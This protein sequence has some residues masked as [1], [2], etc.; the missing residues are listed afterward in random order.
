LDKT[1]LWCYFIFR[2]QV[3]NSTPNQLQNMIYAFSFLFLAL[4]V[5]AVIATSINPNEY[6]ALLTADDWK[7]GR[8]IREEMSRMKQKK[9]LPPAMVYSA[10]S[11]LVNDG[12][13]EH[14]DESREIEGITIRVVLSPRPK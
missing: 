8:K 10:L 13:V 7:S 9:W 3:S 14:R 2:L 12:L 5:I 6:L 4:V 11:Q 1:S